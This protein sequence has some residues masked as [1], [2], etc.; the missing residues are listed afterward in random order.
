MPTPFCAQTLG[1]LRELALDLS[2][3]T[4]KIGT[5]IAACGDEEYLLALRLSGDEQKVF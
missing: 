2:R 1:Q 4:S 5:A 3:G